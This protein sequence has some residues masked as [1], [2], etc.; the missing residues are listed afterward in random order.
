MR[1]YVNEQITSNP[2][3]HII[4]VSYNI[5]LAVEHGRKTNLPKVELYIRELNT[6]EYSR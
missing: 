3:A 1:C 6:A 2:C 4:M 5:E